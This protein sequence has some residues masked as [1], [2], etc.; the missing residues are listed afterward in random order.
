MPSPI[1][2]G[3]E[4]VGSPCF[5]GISYAA[6]DGLPLTLFPDTTGPSLASASVDGTA[7][8]LT[9]DETLGAAANLANTAFTVKKTPRDGSEETVSLS[10]TPSIAGQAVTLTLASAVVDTDTGVKVTYTV[11]TA[12]TANKVVDAV[13]NTAVGFTDQAVT[14]ATPDTTKPT[15]SSASVD[16]TTL[17]LTFD[18]DLDTSGTAP[19]TGAFAV[20]G[21][22]ATTS[23]TGVAFDTNDA[24]LVVL[25]LSP[26]VAYDDSGITV[27][28][29]RP[30]GAGANPLK[31]PSA[32]EVATFDGQTVSNDTPVP[33]SLALG[34]AGDDGAWGIGEAIEVTATFAESVTV[35]GTPRIPFTLGAAAK[36]LAYASGSPGTAL[37]FAYTVASGDEDT[38]GIEIVANALENHG[39]ST[40]KLTSDGMTD[41]VLGHEAVAASAS[42]RVDGVAPVL[43]S[44]TVNG[45]ALTL[46]YAEALDGSS[47]PAASAFTV[48]VGGSDVSLSG[49]SPVGVA[50]SA[51]TLTL[52]SAVSAGDGVTVSYTVPTDAAAQR[53]QDV[54]GNDAAEL[55]R[56]QEVSN[57]V[58]ER[59]G[60][61]QRQRDAGGGRG[62]RRRGERGCGGDGDGRGRRRR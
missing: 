30:T 18:E 3:C 44:A 17:T 16:G 23:V 8:T 53:I 45:A 35:T 37:V 10:G 11:P 61:R 26:A 20:S 1:V 5:E 62:P 29:T 4:L 47:V 36:H 15:L 6:A 27:D 58:L 42:H 34:A 39:G 24:K 22:A 49:T 2:S 25:T 40:I 9:F 19:A 32:N 38:D 48:R 43:R 51:V 60:V 56:P 57:D 12:G 7:L 46:S 41:A 13:G 55:H 14:N 33:V 31:D 54:A 52:A 28:Y 59:A 50:G 21:T